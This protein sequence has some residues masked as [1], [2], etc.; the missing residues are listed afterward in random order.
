M[1][2]SH[3]LYSIGTVVGT[4]WL[5]KKN[6]FARQGQTFKELIVYDLNITVL[7]IGTY[8]CTD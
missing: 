8:I 2:H 4:R 6:Y 7:D 3:L 1:T 5:L